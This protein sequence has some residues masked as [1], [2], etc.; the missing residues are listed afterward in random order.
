[1]NQMG[2][3]CC[4]YGRHD[5]Y[6][7]DFVGVIYERKRPLERHRH[8]WEDNI[9]LLKPTGDVIHHQFNIQQLYA[10]PTL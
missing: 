5:I 3:S 6:I 2:G 1:M 4:T 8:K 9:N 7:Q 10:L